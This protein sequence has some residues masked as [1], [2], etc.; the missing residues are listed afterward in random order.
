MSWQP[1]L[2]PTHYLNVRVH[3]L[4][5]SAETDI[6]AMALFSLSDRNCHKLKKKKKKKKKKVKNFLAEIAPTHNL[7][8]RWK[9]L[10]SKTKSEICVPSKAHQYQYSLGSKSYLSLSV[11]NEINSILLFIL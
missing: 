11:S 1:Y 9:Y 4:N 2:S 3:V 6:Y 5:A 10:N 8:D 7:F